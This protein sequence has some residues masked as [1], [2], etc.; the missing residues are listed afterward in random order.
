MNVETHDELLLL[1]RSLSRTEKRYLRL[2]VAKQ[3]IEDHKNILDALFR[4]GETTGPFS[5]YLEQHFPHPKKRSKLRRR[6]YE[7]M[8]DALVEYESQ[9]SPDLQLQ[10]ILAHARVLLARGLH[11]PL[12]KMIRKGLKLARH[13]DRKWALAHL[14]DLQANM[15]KLF[16]LSPKNKTLGDSAFQ[17][18]YLAAEDYAKLQKLAYEDAIVIMMFNQEGG[19]GE[20]ETSLFEH[21]RENAET[22]IRAGG[23]VFP[24][25]GHHLLANLYLLRGDPLSMSGQ[26]NAIDALFQEQPQ[27]IQGL[28]ASYYR[29]LH[30]Q[31]L[32]GIS[33]LKKE[34]ARQT[35]NRLGDAKP[36]RHHLQSSWF[37]MYFSALGQFAQNIGETAALRQYI[38]EYPAGYKNHR[39]HLELVY[40]LLMEM[41]MAV[42]HFIL[43]EY[44]QTLRW[45]HRFLHNEQ[46]GITKKSTEI[47]SILR[48]CVYV[49]ME[50]WESLGDMLEKTRTLLGN[51]LVFPRFWAIC[52][53]YF[54][55]L[56][57][58]PSAANRGASLDVFVRECHELFAHPEEHNVIAHF[59]FRTW[60]KAKQQGIS[61]QEGIKQKF[62]VD[63]GSGST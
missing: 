3:G 20:K 45:I 59:D 56:V 36:A 9:H 30:F 43:E 29:M 47:L 46:A 54:S 1:Y 63:G 8:L 35:L 27:M 13:Y 10:Q 21:M 12:E 57:Q 24:Y 4:H 41:L 50:D 51:K 26:W 48:L 58:D 19:V 5:D 18:A 25:Y 32:M 52:D 38:E 61:M 31:T 49:E 6:L 15:Q 17:G 55:A 11:G 28:E 40:V 53:R 39:D 34:E 23:F 16:R 42:C 62:S 14:A 7:S 2:Y 33:L 37:Q 60:G 44:T 22:A